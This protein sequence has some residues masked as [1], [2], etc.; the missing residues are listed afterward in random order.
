MGANQTVALSKLG[1]QTSIVG[2]VGNDEQGKWLLRE[3]KENGADVTGVRRDEYPTG[4][5]VQ[6]VTKAD[7]APQKFNV[8]CLGQPGQ[9]RESQEDTDKAAELLR[10]A[11]G[12]S[13]AVLLLQ[14]EISVE[15]MIKLVR[16][17]ACYDSFCG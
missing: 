2:R 4:T 16:R 10:S 7:T 12:G 9:S 1:I 8:I 6:I 11:T 3:L 5:A 17:L 13:A 15:L 14:L